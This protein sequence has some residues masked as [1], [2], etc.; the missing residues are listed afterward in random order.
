MWPY[1]KAIGAGAAIVALLAM[2]IF[3]VWQAWISQFQGL[4]TGLA[5]VG[6][7]AFTIAKMEKTIRVME[8]TDSASER[9]HRQLMRLSLRADKLR[10]ERMYFPHSRELQTLHRK[11]T[12]L[13]DIT[14]A[15]DTQKID[16]IRLELEL[17]ADSVRSIVSGEEWKAAG[18]LFGG[19]LTHQ[20]KDLL[21]AAHRLGYAAQQARP[22]PFNDG[23]Q[24]QAFYATHEARRQE[25]LGKVPPLVA[26]LVTK[27]ESTLKEVRLLAIAYEIY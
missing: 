12:E 21:S 10:I 4:I 17:T 20:V 22:L 11:L 3:P 1:L 13:A 15:N 5:A 8:R 6:A 18:N 25:E 2:F 16:P 7:A 27:L 23:Q 9:R 24:P 19:I 26:E 14:A